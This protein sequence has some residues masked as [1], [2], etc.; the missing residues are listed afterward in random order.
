M[1]ERARSIGGTLSAA[2][3]EDA[4]GFAVTA[5]LPLPVELPVATT[6]GSA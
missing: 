2:P 6:E 1:R 4:P 5:K 3:R